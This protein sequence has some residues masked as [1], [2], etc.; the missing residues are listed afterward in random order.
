MATDLLG[1]LL[2]LLKEKIQDVDFRRAWGPGW[3][4]RLLEGPVVSA[5]VVS[6]RWSGNSLETAMKLSV[7]AP[8]ASLR[9][10]V[11]VSL[12]E[13]VRANCP[14]CREVLRKGEQEDSITR[15]PFQTVEL[16]FSGGEEAGVQGIPVMLG[17]KEYSAAGV[18]VSIALSGNELVAIGEDIPFAVRDAQTEY[19]VSLEGI[20]TTGLERLA[21]FTAE[22]GS[23]VYTGCRWKKLDLQTG[24]AVFLAANC[25]EKEESL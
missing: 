17:G 6:E 1:D 19:Q 11:A 7:F 4:S 25:E 14:G 9:E 10:K 22:I 18:T 21:V 5:E 15:L 3:G 23:T 20:D 16:T 8:D 12:E 13:T 2:I 24:N